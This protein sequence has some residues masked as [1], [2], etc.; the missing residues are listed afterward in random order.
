M[1]TRLESITTR[2]AV[3]KQ[4]IIA[5]CAL[6]QI[7][8]PAAGPARTIDTWEGAGAQAAATTATAIAKYEV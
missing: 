4:N 1:A 7:R 2:K 3:A 6:N 5:R 8:S